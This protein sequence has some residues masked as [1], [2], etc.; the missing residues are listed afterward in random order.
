MEN[1]VLTEQGRETFRVL[2]LSWYQLNARDLPW[3]HTRDPYRIWVSEVM[4]QQTR[5]AAV[6]ARYTQFIE[7]FPS[8]V[9]LALARE[10]EVVALWSGL[11]YY[12]R[13]RMLHSAAQLLMKEHGGSL[14][15]SSLELRRLPGVGDY[16]AAAIASIARGEAVAVIDGNVERVLMRVLGKGAG[17][18]GASA[19]RLKEVASW[20]LA[21]KAPGTFNQAMMELGAT[22]C[23]PHGPLCGS[24]PVR[25]FCRTQGEHPVRPRKQMVSVKSHYALVKKAA[26]RHVEVL[27]VQRPPNASQMPGMWE[28]PTLGDHDLIESKVSEPALRIRHSITNKNFY[29]QVFPLEVETFSRL[30]SASDSEKQDWVA[31]SNLP[32]IP[33]TGLARKILM[34]LDV[35]AK[36]RQVRQG[37]ALP[38]AD[39]EFL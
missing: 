10:E 11:G 31:A 27:L 35:L 18:R 15:K 34:R 19:A 3:R 4:L 32:E 22:V 23:L 36:P 14:P 39:D 30:A 37:K 21:P 24:C 33:L 13:A 25:E 9:A 2:L 12:R 7:R 26:G 29:V 28:L 6:V 8:I 38:G 16:T 5:A 17:S 1:A 20:L